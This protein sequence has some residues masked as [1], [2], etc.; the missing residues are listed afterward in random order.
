VDFWRER[1]DVEK[2][3]MEVTKLSNRKFTRF[4]LFLIFLHRAGGGL[5]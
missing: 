4:V 5:A 3:D 1:E 2:D